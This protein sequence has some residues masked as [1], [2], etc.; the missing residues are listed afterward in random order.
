[1]ET[2]LAVAVLAGIV[3]AIGW[4]ATHRSNRALALRKDRL[5]FVNKQ[6]SELYG[7]L[8]ISC[9]AGKTAYTTLL[10]KLNRTSGIFEQKK[11]PSEEEIKEWFHWMKNVL[12]PINERRD[13]L[14]LGNCHLL[15]EDKVPDCII[16]FSSHVAAYRAILAKWENNDYQ[17]HYSTVPFPQ[18]LDKYAEDSFA[19]LKVE[20][21]RLLSMLNRKR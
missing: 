15:I 1:M 2:A 9:K 12:G 11:H 21:A 20:Q 19:K 18:D 4:Y 5:E 13:A 3:T 6:L 8:H 14:I 17:E 10:K 16:D 7:P